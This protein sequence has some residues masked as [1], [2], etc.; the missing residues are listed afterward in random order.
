MKKHKNGDFIECGICGAI[1]QYADNKIDTEIRHDTGN[2]YTVL[3][4]IKCPDCQS[5]IFI[6]REIHH[7]E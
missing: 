4:Y 3:K 2:T 1:T 5:L 7:H 6:E